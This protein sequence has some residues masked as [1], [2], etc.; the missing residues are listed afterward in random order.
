MTDG[1]QLKYGHIRGG[2]QGYSGIVAASQT[3]LA[4]SGKFVYRTGASTATYTLGA[5]AIGE[6]AGWMEIEAIS[7]T[8][9][10]EV[11]KIINDLTAVFR[12]PINSGTYAEY[13][14]G[15]TCDMSVSSNVQG[16]QLDASSEDT[17]IIVGGD[18]VN[19]VWVDVMINPNKI[20]AT[21]VV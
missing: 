14:K 13:M 11:R 10:T 16:A 12:I 21:G 3:I 8:A 18:A 5:D 15:K 2:T 4:A 19:N 7:S 17:L 20:G 1:K 6:I 9:G